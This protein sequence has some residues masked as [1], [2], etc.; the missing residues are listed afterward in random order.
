[1]SG[2][3]L[4]IKKMNFYTVRALLKLHSDGNFT[5]L[6]EVQVSLGRILKPFFWFWRYSNLQQEHPT[7]LMGGVSTSPTF[8][9]GRR[10]QSAVG[11]FLWYGTPIHV[12]GA[13]RISSGFS[14]MHGSDLEMLIYIPGFMW[15][16]IAGTKA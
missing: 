6:Q 4:R 1:M 11:S 13:K 9:K 7:V 2:L 8:L 3:K 10:F 5:S 12:G 15:M 14:V 16:G